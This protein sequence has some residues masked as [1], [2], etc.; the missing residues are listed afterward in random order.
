MKIRAIREDTDGQPEA[1]P[2]VDQTLNTV[3]ACI[4]RARKVLGDGY[5]LVPCTLVV[6]DRGNEYQIGEIVAIND[7]LSGEIIYAQIDSIEPRIEK[8]DDGGLKTTLQLG[9]LRL[10]YEFN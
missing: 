5:G 3:E 6:V 4:E 9:L 1:D 2:I 10:P 8:S 7:S